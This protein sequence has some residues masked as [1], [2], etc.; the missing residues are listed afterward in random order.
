MDDEPEE[1]LLG[2][3]AQIA[4]LV[5]LESDVPGAQISGEPIQRVGYLPVVIEPADLFGVLGQRHRL[6]PPVFTPVLG[7]E[8]RQ[9]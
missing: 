4:I 8:E 7:N 9:H 2:A 6:S 1:E 3:A 5:G